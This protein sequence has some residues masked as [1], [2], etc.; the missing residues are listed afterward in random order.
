MLT[1]ME[2]LRLHGRKV[3]NTVLK[4]GQI[5][6]GQTCIVRF[7]LGTPK[8]VLV[9]PPTSTVFVGT[10]A[11]SSVHKHSVARNRMRRRLKE[12]FRLQIVEQTNLPTIQLLISPKQSSLSAPFSIVQTD[13][14]QF[15]Q[16][17]LS[18]PS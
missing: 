9:A 14:D 18:L 8:T 17:I 7:L 15:F 10:F 3:N 12:A 11:S 4:K 6:R 5:W 16:F 2:V 1:Y 13:I